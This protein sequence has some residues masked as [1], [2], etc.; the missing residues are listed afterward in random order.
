ME[1]NIHICKTCYKEGILL[2][3]EK[4]H[5]LGNDFIVVDGRDNYITNPPVI[6]QKMCNRHT[7]VGAD[8]F[9]IIEPSSSA[10]IRMR[11]FNSDGSEGEMCGNGIRCFARFV[12]EKGIVKKTDFT[13]ETLGGIMKPVVIMDDKGRFE[14][15]VVDMG[16]PA[17]NP[18]KIPVNFNGEIFMD[19]PVDIEGKSYRLSSVLMGVPHTVVYMD[20]LKDVDVEGVGRIIETHP[21]FPSKTNVNFV[22]VDSRK[23]IKV[24]TWERGAGKT[25]ACGT[26]CCSAVVISSILD[27]TDKKVEVELPLGN[28][29]I[30]W[31]EDGHVYMQGPAVSICRGIWF[32]EV[33]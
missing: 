22:Q 2:K 9:I 29:I 6:S 27:K 14:G 16:I 30:E 21:L 12:V 15:V 19:I 10:D 20:S 18:G 11:Y 33:K 17:L 31:C 13:V 26:G 1:Y 4:M 32:D 24:R 7:G 3:F 5:G 28:L 8:G 25:L 23:K